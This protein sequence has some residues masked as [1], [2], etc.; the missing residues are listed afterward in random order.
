MTRS[1]IWVVMAVSCCYGEPR[2]LTLKQAVGLALQQSPELLLARLDEQKAVL[3]V[4]AI[5]EPMLPRVI[6]GSGLAY[7]SGMPMS[8]DGAA[9]AVVQAKAVRSLWNPQQG[10]QVAQAKEGVRTAAIVTNAVQEDLALR[11]ASLFLDLERAGKARELAL[12]QLEQLQRVEASVRLR[13]A[14]GRE[15]P[16]EG[17]KSAANVARARMRVNSLSSS[18]AAYSRALAMVLG[19]PPSE[20]IV[21]AGEQRGALEVPAD[22][23]KGLEEV[24]SHDLEIRRL[25]SELAAKN[26]EVRATRAARLPKVDLVAQYGLLSKF[27]NY[28]D[29]FQSFKRNNVQVGASI[30]MPLFASSADEARASQSEVE[31]RRIRIRIAQQRSKV[32]A[33]YRQKWEQV[34]DT[35]AAREVARMDLDVAREQVS[36]VLAQMEE[37]RATM[38]QVD[39]ARFQEQEKWGQYFDAGYQVELATMELLRRSSTLV[40][41]L[42]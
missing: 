16:V 39:E 32:E 18:Q 3:E 33:E 21:P 23:E 29:Y 22:H 11:V 31:A 34:R 10:Y 20:E 14:E 28:E 38:R 27:N 30:Q 35:Q 13:V 2:V 25:E 40:A 17:K 6:V 7:T 37:G 5:K 24:T 41:A 8:I 19:L 15:L 42:K 36:V 1:A 12:R 4:Q 26:L 9:P